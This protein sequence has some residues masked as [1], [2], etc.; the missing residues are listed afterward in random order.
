[1]NDSVRSREIADYFQVLIIAFGMAAIYGMPYLRQ[2]YQT[3]IIESFAI[4]NAQFGDLHSLFALGCLLSYLPGGWLADKISPKYLIIFSLI[5]TGLLNFW[6][7]TMPSYEELKIIHALWGVTTV[8]TLWA[9]V[10]KRVR[11]LAGPE[12]QGRFFG[13]LEGTRGLFEA[14]IASGLLL[15]FTAF[16][17]ESEGLSAVM[18][19]YAI[20]CILIGIGMFFFKDEEDDGEKTAVKVSDLFVVMRSPIV[21][22]CAFIVFC[23]YHLYW[24]IFSI[25]GFAEEAGFGA[26]VAFAASLGTL[27]MWMR[28]VGG[29]VGGF[30]GDKIG[31][32]NGVLLSKLICV[33][34]L[35]IFILM[36]TTPETLII[37]WV[38]L[39][40][41]AIALYAL[42]GLFWAV[43]EGA[44]IP[45]YYAGTAVGFVSIVG[46]LPDFFLPQVNG[47]FMDTYTGAEGYKLYFAYL[48]VMGIVG[49]LVALTLKKMVSKKAESSVQ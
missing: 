42:R 14:M 40:P 36:P 12:R 20:I 41:F 38:A 11:I 26:T 28:P 44:D 27:Q 33:I 19:G 18:A 30:T 6:Y 39:V 16:A 22:L 24:A 45:K 3:T 32:I 8:L 43:L 15:V 31:N 35:L 2:Y 5:S 34:S 4:T 47:Y 48:M 17:V 1:M 25:P 9:A 23:S 10:L 21:W 49:M 37:L 29:I 46:Y 7:S 13:V